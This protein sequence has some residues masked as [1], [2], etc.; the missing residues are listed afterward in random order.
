MVVRRLLAF[1]GMS[2]PLETAMPPPLL[3]FSVRWVGMAVDVLECRYLAAFVRICEGQIV[4]VWCQDQIEVSQGDVNAFG[5]LITSRTTLDP[6]TRCGLGDDNIAAA[7]EYRLHHES[8]VLDEARDYFKLAVAD[9]CRTDADAASACDSVVV[10]PQL[11]EER[12]TSNLELPRGFGLVATV[13]LERRKNVFPFKVRQRSDLH[14]WD[15][16][17]RCAKP[18]FA[19]QIVHIDES[20][21][22]ERAG[23]LDHILQLPHVARPVVLANAFDGG[24]GVPGDSSAHA[25]RDAAQEARGQ[26]L[27]VVWPLAQWRDLKLDDFEAVVQVAAKTPS[28]NGVSEVV[29]R[30]GDDSHVNATRPA[31]T[32]TA[33]LTLL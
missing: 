8:G 15:D 2:V 16:A 23:T 4:G 32:H 25:L 5:G 12:R 31:V 20:T 27:Y 17:W 18:E 24:R 19:R 29:I 26:S 11:T 28:G 6:D 10:T 3:N 9:D 1:R 21:E 33:N 13:A 14:Y 22:R 7:A 30:G